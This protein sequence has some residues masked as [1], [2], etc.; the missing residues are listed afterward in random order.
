MLLGVL[1][2]PNAIYLGVLV[3]GTSSG[4]SF[5]YALSLK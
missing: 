1:L 3:L 5:G 2:P 4:D